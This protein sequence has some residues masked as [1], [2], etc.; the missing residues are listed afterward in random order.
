MKLVKYWVF[1]FYEGWHHSSVLS[2]WSKSIDMGTFKAFDRRNIFFRVGLRS[3]RSIPPIYVRSRSHMLASC[4]WDKLALSLKTRIRLPKYWQMLSFTAFS[5]Y[6]D[7]SYFLANDTFKSTDY[8]YHLMGDCSYTS[9][10]ELACRLEF[11]WQRHRY[12]F[13]FIYGG[14]KN[15]VQHLTLR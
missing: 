2:S 3:P 4:S 6:L 15:L 13:T 1:Y 10:E 14:R 7:L 12:K 11:Y 5:D 8:K 9:L